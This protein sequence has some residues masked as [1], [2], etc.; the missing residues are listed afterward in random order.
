[1]SFQLEWIQRRR[2]VLKDA[3]CYDSAKIAE[4]YRDLFWS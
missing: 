1:M 4:A 2:Q 3:R